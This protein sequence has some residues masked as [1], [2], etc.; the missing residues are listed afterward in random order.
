MKSV[1]IIESREGQLINAL[2]SFMLWLLVVFSVIRFEKMKRD[3]VRGIGMSYPLDDIS[4]DTVGSA[5]LEK[6][7]ASQDILDAML[8]Q[9]AYLSIDE[10]YAGLVSSTLR[11]NWLV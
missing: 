11:Y 8:A 5:E 3:E 6:D 10:A 7:E 9:E 4:D 1:I 2:I